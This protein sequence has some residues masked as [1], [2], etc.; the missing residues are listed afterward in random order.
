MRIKLGFVA[1]CIGFAL[2]PMSVSTQVI[3]N[4][5]YAMDYATDTLVKLGVKFSVE[6]ATAMKR[7]VTKDGP[8]HWDVLYPNGEFS[9]SLNETSGAVTG[10]CDLGLSIRMLDKNHAKLLRKI[11][12]EED[13]WATADRYLVAARLSSMN[14]QRDSLE[15]VCDQV[16]ALTDLSGKGTRVVARY[17][18]RAN[19]FDG[20][21]NNATITLDV[22][23]GQVEVASASTIWTF[24]QPRSTM[25]Q[26]DALAR[27]KVLFGN[28][29]A[30]LIGLGQETLSR[31]FQ[32]PGDGIVRAAMVKRVMDGGESCFGSDYGDSVAARM[33]ARV[34]W[35]YHSEIVSAAIDAENGEPVFGSPSKIL[36]L[37][38]GVGGDEPKQG[39][40]DSNRKREERQAGERIVWLIGSTLL[41]ALLGIVVF[42]FTKRTAIR[43]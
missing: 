2:V 41:L 7:Q 24:E 29:E 37:A 38:H 23:E 30:R 35:E 8:V 43:E 36:G 9:V 17:V 40:L 3:K 42:R 26:D 31:S 10:F 20:G 4:E 21:V 19:G 25:S 5:G 15:W 33:V 39:A 12:N 6:N 13:A 11:G 27:M 32:W 34:C 16:G 14:F 22:I 18:Q 1:V 28:E